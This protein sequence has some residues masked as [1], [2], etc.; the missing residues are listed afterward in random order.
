M[1]A[2]EAGKA[3]RPLMTRAAQRIGDLVLSAD[4]KQRRRAIVALMTAGVY[5]I[6]IVILFYGGER[7]IFDPGWTG[8]LALACGSVVTAFYAAIRSGFNLR[9]SAPSLALPQAIC[10]QTLV[11]AAYMIAGPAH[12]SMLALAAM[13][14]VF[15]MFEMRTRYVW[16]LMRYTLVLM[17]AVMVWCALHD[18]LTYPPEVEVIHYAILATVLPAISSLSAQLRAMR[19]RL[20]KQ[21]AELE[22]ALE[23]IRRVATLDELTGLPNR[24]HMRELLAEHIARFDRGGPAFAVALADLDHFKSINDRFGHAVGD[25]VLTGFADRARA[26]LRTTDIVGRWGGEEFVIILAGSPPA[27]LDSGMERMRRS[28][29]DTPVCADVPEIR[30]TFSAGVTPYRK[31]ES[32]DDVIERADKALYDAK[33]AGRDRSVSR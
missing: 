16:L 9:F 7:G 23:K 21:K 24:R 5:A 11:A 4:F 6:C 10:A 1:D 12:P 18:P 28:L 29:R 32:I 2:I 31:G 17:G 22:T 20:Q 13:V 8:V 19:E 3:A 26:H 14:I 33:H 15:G 30:L 27:D 25:D